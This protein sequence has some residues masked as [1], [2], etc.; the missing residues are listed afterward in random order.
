MYRS[1]NSQEPESGRFEGSVIV[2]VF[3]RAGVPESQSIDLMHDRP[4]VAKAV[5]IGEDLRSASYNLA[6][7]KEAQK[8]LFG[9]R[10]RK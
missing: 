5:K 7:D 9:Q 1:G 6:T 8:I 10:A 4:A 3:D 2:R